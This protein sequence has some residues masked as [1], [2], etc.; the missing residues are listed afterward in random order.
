MT[1]IKDGTDLTGA[2]HINATVRELTNNKYTYKDIC[3]STIADRAAKGVSGH[4]D[5]DADVCQ[6]HDTDKI[7]RSAAV[8]LTRRKDLVSLKN[9]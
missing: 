3:H 7:A 4:L 2:A 5:H 6:M 1:P 9:H 8:L